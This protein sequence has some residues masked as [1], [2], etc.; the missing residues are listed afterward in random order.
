MTRILQHM[1]CN[2]EE[3]AD[4]TALAGWLALS[5]VYCR[6]C[7]PKALDK[8]L[9]RQLL[10]LNQQ[11]PVFCRHPTPL[12]HLR[13]NIGV[14]CCEGPGIMHVHSRPADPVL[15]CGPAVGRQ[16]QA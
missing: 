12:L 6:L 8:K 9:L 4:R 7:P 13:Y 10:G 1:A 14:F 11:V 3:A 16:N 2:C 5:V 15:L